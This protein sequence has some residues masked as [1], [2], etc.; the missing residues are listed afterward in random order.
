MK[1][2]RLV[3]CG[4][5]LVPT[6]HSISADVLVVD[7]GGGADHTF[8]QAAVDAA[9]D[10]DTIL[11]RGGGYAGFSIV[12]R[13]L[14][15]VADAGAS[16]SVSGAVRVLDLSIE[17]DVLLAG[18]TGIGIPS[19]VDDL[20]GHGL[21]LRD[22]FGSVRVETSSFTGADNFDAT[23]PEDCIGFG[24]NS[25]FH[26]AL[27]ENCADV[28]L[29]RSEFTGGDG[30]I[31]PD[32]FDGLGYC[33]FLLPGGAGGH[34]VFADAARVV[35][36]DSVTVGGNGEYG[37]QGGRGGDGYRGVGTG[38]V[39]V[40]GTSLTGGEGGVGFDFLF[41]PGGA[42]GDGILTLGATDTLLRDNLAAGG[43]GGPSVVFE[44]GEDGQGVEVYGDLTEF[45][46]VARKLRADS[47]VREGEVLALDFEGVTADFAVLLY[48]TPETFLL[49]LFQGALLTDATPGVIVAGTLAGTGQL[50]LEATVGDVDAS[51]GALRVT[52]QGLFVTTKTGIAT[53][54]SAQEVVLL[55]AAF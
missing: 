33:G 37:G 2:S 49:P 53:L 36:S 35:L 50:T 40:A 28:V 34:G 52:L 26:G 9:A 3:L 39:V 1:A 31:L 48:G 12:D 8:I 29:H 4:C 11:V 7:G 19:L 42:G 22:N 23:L 38:Q 55:D 41:G 6:A 46:Q 30:L 5:A 21:V 18:L 13:S 51:L 14:N 32:D 47:P 43:A 54:G 25:G 44:A 45:A 27:A 20:A 24:D 10:G 17:K 16:V 15:V